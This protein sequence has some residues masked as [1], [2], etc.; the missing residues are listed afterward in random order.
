MVPSGCKVT[1]KRSRYELIQRIQAEVHPLDKNLFRSGEKLERSLR[2]L[3]NI[4]DQVRTATPTTNPLR[5]RETAA[6]A[7]T[8]R[9]CYTAAALRKP[10]ARLPDRGGAGARRPGRRTARRWCN[11]ART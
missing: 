3:D 9:W 2:E 6:M 7:A 10:H 4:W 1:A 5:A 11:T 8:A